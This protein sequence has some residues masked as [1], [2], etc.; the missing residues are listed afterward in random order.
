[1]FPWIFA[2]NRDNVIINPLRIGSRREEKPGAMIYTG[3]I[4]SLEKK[5]NFRIKKQRI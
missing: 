5:L 2:E 4:V 1:M 3:S